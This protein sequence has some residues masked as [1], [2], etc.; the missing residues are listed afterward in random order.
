[1][2]NNTYL[3]IVEIFNKL[4]KIMNNIK[5][6]NLI[7]TLT[8]KKGR[9]TLMGKNKSVGR[10]EKVSVALAFTKHQSAAVATAAENTI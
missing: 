6:Q 1:M 9:F 3:N 5:I 7:V 2:L 8:R 10:Q 4:F